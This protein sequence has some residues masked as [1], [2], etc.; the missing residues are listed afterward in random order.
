[1]NI[2]EN[3]YQLK[4]VIALEP[5][6]TTRGGANKPLFITAHNPVDNKIEDFV[7]KYRGAER[8]DERT[9][10]RELI[11]AFLAMELDIPVPEPAVVYVNDRFLNLLTKHPDY[12]KIQKSK[13]L[14]FGSQKIEET[15]DMMPNQSLSPNHLKQALRIFVLDIAIQNADRNF[16][17]PNMFLSQNKI[18]VIDH[19]IA[20]GFIDT[21]SFLRSPNPYTFNE[22]DIQS[23]K[24]HFFYPLLRHVTLDN[25]DDAVKP[26]EKLNDNFWKK[27][28]T[29]VPNEWKTSEIDAISSHINQI[30]E[31]L[32]GFKKEIWTILQT[33]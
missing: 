33:P 15:V 17:K 2:T 27:L 13:G 9:C 26:F 5:T 22:T 28:H 16:Q 11:G 18:F 30:V 29:F 7:L 23:F 14:N 10:A 6:G 21:F 25:L 12:L 20:F 19:E 24:K 31:H 8:M 4:Q 3:N 1:M 32:T